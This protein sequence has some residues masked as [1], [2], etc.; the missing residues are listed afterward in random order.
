VLELR[1]YE[2]AL[3]YA[4]KAVA[5]APDN[6]DYGNTLGTCLLRLERFEEAITE[7]ERASELS[8]AGRDL[9]PDYLSLVLAHAGLDD[10]PAATVWMER[11]ERAMEGEAPTDSIIMALLEEARAALGEED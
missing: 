4:Q 9:V 2:R 11:A 5:L 7:L 6:P 10:E 1:D 3:P 8:G